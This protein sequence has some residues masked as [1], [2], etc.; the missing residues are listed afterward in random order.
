MILD[1]FRPQGAGLVPK[2]S[3]CNLQFSISNLL[4]QPPL[5]I[6]PKHR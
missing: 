1:L 3:I 5:G 6:I 2:T 4:S